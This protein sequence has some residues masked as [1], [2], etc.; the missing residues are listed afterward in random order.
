MEQATNSRISNPII[1]LRPWSTGG[2]VRLPIV[3]PRS[4]AR[5]PFVSS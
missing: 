1:E 4:F 5:S 3:S 2:S